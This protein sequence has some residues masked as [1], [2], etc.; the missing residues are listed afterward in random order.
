[1]S[2]EGSKNMF[3]KIMTGCIKDNGGQQQHPTKK[4]IEKK[5]SSSIPYERFK[6]VSEDWNKNKYKK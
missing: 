4:E 5:S 1:M 2:K 3:S 6:N